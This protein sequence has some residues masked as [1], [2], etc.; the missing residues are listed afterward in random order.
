MPI[1]PAAATTACSSGPLGCTPT[2]RPMLRATAWSVDM[3]SSLCLATQATTQ[4]GL[5][6]YGDFDGGCKHHA[7]LFGQ[8]DEVHPAICRVETPAHQAVLLQAVQESHNAARGNL[9]TFAESLLREVPSRLDSTHQGEVARLKRKALQLGP[10]PA[11]DR[12]AELGDEK[13]DSVAERAERINSEM[14]PAPDR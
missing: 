6:A 4:L 10:K 12:V 14:A 2:T 8:L 3:S 7:A 11:R 9:E 13:A 5:D 1:V